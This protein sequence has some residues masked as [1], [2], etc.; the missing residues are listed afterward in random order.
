MKKYVKNLKN[1]A[2]NSGIANNEIKNISVDDKIGGE[3]KKDKKSSKKKLENI[4][5]KAEEAN[6]KTIKISKEEAKKTLNKQL[7]IE[8]EGLAYIPTEWRTEILCYEFK[9]NVEGKEFLV[10]IN[11]ENGREE[12]ILVITNT[13]NGTL[14]M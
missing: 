13:P 8:S 12:D 11:A 10:Y 6:G 5:L 1:S 7:N 14:T 2:T 9:G 4:E 3:D